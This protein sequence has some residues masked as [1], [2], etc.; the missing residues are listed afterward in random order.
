MRSRSEAA[1]IS[2]PPR[3][4]RARRA[5]SPPGSVP[6]AAA[7]SAAHGREQA[8][9]QRIGEVGVGVAGLAHA[10]GAGEHPHA[11]QERLLLAEDAGAVEHVLEG[12]RLGEA[13]R[14]QVGEHRLVGKAFEEGRLD[15]RIE[16]VGAG[17]HGLGQPRRRGEDRRQKI[18]QVGIGL[19]QR[20][21]LD[22]GRHAGEEAVEGDERRVGVL[23]LR[24]RL[25]QDRHELGQPLARAGRAGG[26]IAAVVPVADGAGDLGGLAVAELRASVAS[27][28]GSSASPVKTRLPTAAVSEGACSNSSV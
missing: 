4:P 28:S 26:R 11:D 24:Q 20:E 12:D 17:D 18:E 25:D 3:R 6:W 15:H 21:E 19:K 9:H 5:T 23:G 8:R 22:A 16:D 2:R 14:E 10:D 13:R 7:N 1:V 27:V